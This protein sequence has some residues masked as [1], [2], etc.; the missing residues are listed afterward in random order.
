MVKR[1]VFGFFRASGV[2]GA[3]SGGVWVHPGVY[4][5]AQE[6][7]SVVLNGGEQGVESMMT[8]T[9]L[10]TWQGCRM[11]VVARQRVFG[12]PGA[13]RGDGAGPVGVLRVQIASEMVGS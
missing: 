9:S 13:N 3:C 6:L 1:L 11:L 5:A 8:N 10:M 2:L 12:V 7:W 4:F